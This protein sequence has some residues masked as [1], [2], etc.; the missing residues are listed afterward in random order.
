VLD[1]GQVPHVRAVQVGKAAGEQAADIVHRGGAQQEGLA[2][3]GGVR[4][5]GR[6]VKRV[7][8]VALVGEDLL[9]VHHLA[10]A[11]RRELR[12]AGQACRQ[13]GQGRTS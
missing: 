10:S 7:D 3:A 8:A 4:G 13:P 2:Q 9:A 11:R 6:E 5:A 12:L 1:K